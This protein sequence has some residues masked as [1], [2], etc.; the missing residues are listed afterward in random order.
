M[1]V[2]ITRTA[3]ILAV[4]STVAVT[5]FVPT[6]TRISSSSAT[7]T[8]TTTTTKSQLYNDLWGA[9]PQKDGDN[10]DKSLALPFAPRPKLLDGTMPADV[11]FE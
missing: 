11:G 7:A 1:K 2:T 4:T 9:P 10:K 8:T 6:T 3:S 5:A